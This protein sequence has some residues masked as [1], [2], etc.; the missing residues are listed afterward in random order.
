M[1]RRNACVQPA[2]TSFGASRAVIKQGIPS[3]S[4]AENVMNRIFQHLE[5]HHE[6]YGVALFILPVLV[7]SCAAIGIAHGLAWVFR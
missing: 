7:V 6:E 3:A 4:A 5:A 2:T 1:A